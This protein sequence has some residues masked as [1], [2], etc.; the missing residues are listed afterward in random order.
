M[1]ITEEDH[2][3]PALPF[4]H[5][6][7]LRAGQV[8]LVGAGPGDPDL[9]TLKALRRLAEA[10]VVLYDLL[11]AEEILALVNKRARLV[12]VGKRA[13]RH[14]LP[15]QDIN[16]LLLREAQAGWRVVRLKGGDP[17]LFGRG[18]EELA[19]LLAA[20]IEVEVVPGITAAVGA[21][22]AA[23]IPL[24]HRD[25]A[26]GVS[27]VT[28]HRRD[29]AS[30]LDWAAHSGREQ[31]VVVYMGLG[32]AASIASALQANG[33]SGST[34]VAIIEQATTPRQRVLRCTLATLADCVARDCPQPPALLVIGEVVA[35]A[36]G[37]QRQTE[38]CIAG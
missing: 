10:D 35:L 26:Q 17:L 32:E 25:C 27:L 36:A 8:S 38:G 34:P 7:P 20:G 16:Q 37:W 1:L 14:T 23:G 18:G 12:C 6:A 22:A 15:Q 3:T 5:P 4:P 9:L 2:M 33:R 11:V 30:G 19:A 28:G 21:A 31:T 24:T 13:S 29:G